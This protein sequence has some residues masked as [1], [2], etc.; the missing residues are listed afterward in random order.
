MSL[1][2]A[3]DAR[4]ISVVVTI[5]RDVH[6][7]HAQRPRDSKVGAN[8]HSETRPPAT[9]P[10]KWRTVRR[11]ERRELRNFYFGVRSLLS[12][13]FSIYDRAIHAAC[14]NESAAYNTTS[15]RSGACH[16]YA[17]HACNTLVFRPAQPDSAWH[18]RDLRVSLRWA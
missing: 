13:R 9:K 15:T 4:P 17:P 1:F 14:P 5:N 11:T 7:R 18:P 2:R 16:A 12:P 8:S 6:A 3:V 10:L